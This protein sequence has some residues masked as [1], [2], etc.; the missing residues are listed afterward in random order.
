MAKELEY[1]YAD[2]ATKNDV[3]I[4]W[5]KTELERRHE[6]ML[7]MLLRSTIFTTAAMGRGP[8]DVVKQAVP[9][10]GHEDITQSDDRPLPREL[11]RRVNNYIDKTG[12]HVLRKRAAKFS[13]FNAL[14]R[15]DIRDGRL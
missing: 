6:T 1:A 9:T 5:N 2:G 7:N 14:I 13:S 8:M 10:Y 12:Y 15:S 4:Y 3:R 11:M